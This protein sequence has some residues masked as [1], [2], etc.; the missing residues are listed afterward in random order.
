AAPSFL[1][2][3]ILTRFEWVGLMY[4]VLEAARRAFNNG[5]LAVENLGDRGDRLLRRAPLLLLDGFSHRRHGL[6]SIAGV[7]PR[8]IE[9]MLE[10]RPARQT[11]GIRQRAF[12]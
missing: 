5:S 2:V 10:P 6:H 12:G 1:R 9:L 8:S 11:V 4:G 7:E 3:R